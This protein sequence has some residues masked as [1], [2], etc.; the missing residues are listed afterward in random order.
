MLSDISMLPGSRGQRTF[1][2]ASDERQDAA[3]TAG[4]C[5]ADKADI[6]GRC[7]LTPVILEKQEGDNV[8]LQCEVNPHVDLEKFTADCKRTDD[9]FSDSN[10]LIYSRRNG[11]DHPHPQTE[12]YRNRIHLDRDDLRKSLLTLHILSVGL[13]DSGLYKCYIPKLKATFDFTV[14]VKK[15]Q[16]IGIKSSVFSLTTPSVEEKT[17]PSE[18]E[19]EADRVWYYPIAAFG[20]LSIVVLVIFTTTCIE[21]RRR[22]GQENGTELEMRTIHPEVMV[23]AQ[24]DLS[25]W[26]EG[27]AVAQQ[28]A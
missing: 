6:A 2:L 17:N 9:N 26:S 23:G 25:E 22:K 8:T 1:Q 5:F 16:Q 18:A 7:Y 13:S 24:S 28:E 21:L 12:Q 20:L 27:A 19:K 10:R 4:R 11:H 3:C 14:V 15:A